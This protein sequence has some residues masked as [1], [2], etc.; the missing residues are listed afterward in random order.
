ME[1]RGW[2]VLVK[3]V[4]LITGLGML[5]NPMP[6]TNNAAY[7]DGK[8]IGRAIGGFLLV[9]AAIPFGRPRER[10]RNGREEEE[11]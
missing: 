5:V 2:V 8:M 11:L 10:I 9:A 3:V 1:S 7:D 6:L 4:L